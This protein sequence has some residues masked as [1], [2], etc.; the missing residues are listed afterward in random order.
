M[1][2]KCCFQDVF[3]LFSFFF[4]VLFCSLYEGQPKVML[5][6]LLASSRE[7]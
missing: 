7:V 4:L 6:S 1:T 2:N 3:L 5:F